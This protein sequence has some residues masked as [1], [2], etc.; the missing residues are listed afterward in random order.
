MV[1]LR[2][3][4][5]RLRFSRQASRM[6]W[7]N[8][9]N[10]AGFRH[11]HQPVAP[12]PAQLAFYAAF[13]VAAGRVAVLAL[14]APVRAKRDDPIRLHTLVSAQNLLHHGLHVVVA[15][16]LEDAA[17]VGEGMFVGFQQRLL[18]GVRIGPVEGIAR[19][20]A[21]HREEVQL[22]HFA[23]QYGHALEPIHLRF[24]AQLVALRHEYFPP[25]ESQLSLPQPHIAPHRSFPDGVIRMLRHSR[26][27]IR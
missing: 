21:A 18:R 23:A 12:E 11:G 16:G 8:A 14:I 2:P 1:M 26:I 3:R 24:L 20:H 27:Q 17:E 13:F 7:F 9:S 19:A 10:M 4:I 15:Q 25:A 6:R 5:V 22:A